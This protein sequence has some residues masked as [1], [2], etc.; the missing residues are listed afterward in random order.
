MVAWQGRTPA[1]RAGG[2]D[3]GGVPGAGRGG[4]AAVCGSRGVRAAAPDGVKRVR[5]VRAGDWED[6]LQ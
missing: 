1:E 5:D 4:A 2:C 3:L 6:N